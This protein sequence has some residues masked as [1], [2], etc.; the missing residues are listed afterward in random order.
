MLFTLGKLFVWAIQPSALLPLAT[1]LGGLVAVVCARR[2]PRLARLGRGIAVT[3]FGLLAL[4]MLTPIG[5]LAVAP[6]EARFPAPA[7]DAP[8]P[9]GILLLGGFVDGAAERRDGRV[10]Y[11]RGAEAIGEVASLARRWPAIPIVVTGDGPIGPDGVDHAQAAIMARLL[12]AAGV[13]ANRIVVVRRPRNT[14]E[15]AVQTR[16]MLAPGPGARWLLVTRA[17]HMPR[18]IGAFRAAGWDGI[19]A[20]PSVG[21]GSSHRSPLT[22][23]SARLQVVDLAFREWTGLLAYRL[24]GRSSALLPAP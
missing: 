13:E 3:A 18:A 22:V 2:L 10:K 20:W 5:L 24:V 7:A 9:E 15:E 17:W 16:V 1:L 11:T 21:E 4:L 14:W 23:P 6:L 19:V 8:P 12:V